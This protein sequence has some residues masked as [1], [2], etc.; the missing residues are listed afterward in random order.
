MEVLI[1]F[2]SRRSFFAGRNVKINGLRLGMQ[3]K[4]IHRFGLG[5]YGFRQ[6]VVLDEIDVNEPDA[7][8]TS[9]VRFNAGYVALFYEF[10]FFKTKRWELMTPVYLGAGNVDVTYTDTAGL[11]RPLVQRPFSTGEITFT[12]Q[13]KVWPWFALGAG[14]G[15]RLIFNAEPEIRQAF[16]SPIYILKASV[17]FGE[18]YK[19]IFKKGKYA[20]DEKDE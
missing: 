3:Y 18:L 8:D 10:V 19:I 5:F 6:G 12:A 20:K 4:D 7:T 16:N 14:A 15:Y 2:D 13:F 9:L 17:L 1:G 11:Y